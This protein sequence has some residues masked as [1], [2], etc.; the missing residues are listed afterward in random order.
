MVYGSARIWRL[1][2]I[3]TFH[4]YGLGGLAKR[5]IIA[6]AGAGVSLVLWYITKEPATALFIIIFIDGIGGVLT[7]LKS[8]D[9]QKPRH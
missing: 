6:L 3:F 5:D 9:I 2:N 7:M 4:K 1:I 8:Y